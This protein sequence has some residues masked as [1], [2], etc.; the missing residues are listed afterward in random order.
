MR[1]IEYLYDHIGKNNVEIWV[2]D[3]EGAQTFC[4]TEINVQNN[5][6][7]IPNCKPKTSTPPPTP[8]APIVTSRRLNGTVTTITDKTP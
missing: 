8:V 1:L 2:T 6:A 4:M 3:S 5:G 7:N